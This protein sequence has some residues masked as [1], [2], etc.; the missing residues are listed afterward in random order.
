VDDLAEQ[1]ADL[2]ARRERLNSSQLRK[3]FGEVKDLSRRLKKGQDYRTQIE[4]AFKMLRSKA[5]YA[6]H[7]TGGGGTPEEF[8]QFIDNGVRKVGDEDAF[9]KFVAHFEAVV[10]FWFGKHAR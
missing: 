8:V 6:K 4:P 9:E 5:Q 7:K 2:F 1:Q 10:G 3:F